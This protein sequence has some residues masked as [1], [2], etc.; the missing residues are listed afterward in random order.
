MGAVGGN[1]GGKGDQRKVVQE[2]SDDSMSTKPTPK[3]DSF[4]DEAP[5]GSPAKVSK[6]RD[7]K[8][9]NPSIG[10]DESPSSKH[11]GVSPHLHLDKMS[12]SLSA[13]SDITLRLRDPNTNAFPMPKAKKVE[14]LSD[15][16]FANS[17][18]SKK[19]VAIEKA[20]IT[21][22]ILRVS[23]WDRVVSIMKSSLHRFCRG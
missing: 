3:M 13:F 12:E 23:A 7:K 6:A 11:F 18:M 9:Q 16:A 2:A 19:D 8:P 1:R 20:I 17:D 4:W 21:R 5:H 10:S 15:T 22:K 14:S